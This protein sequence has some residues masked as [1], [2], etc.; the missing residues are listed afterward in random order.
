MIKKLL[1]TGLS[2]LSL[3]GCG[4]NP[5]SDPSTFTNVGQGK[6]FVHL[7]DNT[8]SIDLSALSNS[9]N[10]QLQNEFKNIWGIDAEVTLLPP[11]NGDK[12]IYFITDFTGLPDAYKSFTGVHNSQGLGYI[13]LNLTREYD[14]TSYTASHEVLELLTN[15]NVDPGGRECCDP[16]WP[17][18]YS[19]NGIEVAD[20]V[21]PNYYVPNSQGPWDFMNAV[22]RPLLPIPGGS[23]FLKV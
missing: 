3:F 15:P 7:V 20:F 12:I 22:K 8:S 5:N 17:L 14:M 4:K 16:V 19:I 9:L 23:N 2:L 6:I 18:H 21:F 10:S 13:N 11:K 1:I